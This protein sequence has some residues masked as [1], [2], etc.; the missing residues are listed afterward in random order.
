[1]F[2]AP[3][4][5]N[6]HQGEHAG[7]YGQ[8]GYELADLAVGRAE[9]PVAGEHVAEVYGHVERGHHGVRYGQVDQE[10]VGHVPHPLV[11]HHDPY[12]DQVAARGHHDH[13]HEQHGPRQLVPPRQLELVAVGPT[14]GVRVR[15]VTGRVAAAKIRRPV[16]GL[17]RPGNTH[18]NSHA[19]IVQVSSRTLR[20]KIHYNS[21]RPRVH[22]ENNI[23]TRGCRIFYNANRTRTSTR[24][25]LFRC[26][27]KS[28]IRDLIKKKNNHNN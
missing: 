13:G 10:V 28:T 16:H 24:N 27:T 1:M 7:A 11:G 4:D 17:L 8:H 22:G 18:A 19:L 23:R 2:H 20:T 25:M 12:D 6:G 3:V 21:D 14:G 26:K 15:P 9:G 5:G